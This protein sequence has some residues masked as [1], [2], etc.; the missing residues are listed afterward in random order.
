M[1]VCALMHIFGTRDRGCSAHPAFP[2][3]S[4]FEGTGFHNPGIAPRDR[5]RASLAQMPKTK[6]Q[7]IAV[8]LANFRHTM[9][10]KRGRPDM[11]SS[12]VVVAGFSPDIFERNFMP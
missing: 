5:G 9:A 10:A 7:N 8:S 11:T 1:L 12:A 4:V 6:C 3:P 2:A